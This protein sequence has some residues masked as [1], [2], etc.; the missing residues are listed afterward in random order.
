[1]H[2]VYINHNV[3]DNLFYIIVSILMFF[4]LYDNVSQLKKYK[5]ILLT[6]CMS[7][8]I[9]LCMK[10]PIYI[11]QYC[12]HDLRQ[13]PLFIGTL[14]GGWPTGAALLILLLISR[15]AI[16]GFNL[17]T[18]IVYVVI[19]IATALFSTKFNRLNK[20]KKLF[21]SALITLFLEIITT[22]MAVMISEFFKVTEAYVFYFILVPPL[23]VFFAVYLLELLMDTIHVRSKMVKLEKMEVVSQLAASI[24]HEVRNPLTVVKGFIELLK[25]ANLSQDKKEEYIEHVVRELNNAESII[26][27]YLAFAKPSTEKVEMIIV[28]RE[29]KNIIEILKPWANM[30]S[31]KIKDQLAP[32]SVLGNANYFR[33]CFLN[34][35]KNGVE[36][37]PNGGE[38]EITTFLNKKEL[39]IKVSDT[40]MG[41][42]K[43]QINRFGEPYY[44]SKEKGTGLGSMVAV[45]TI[46]M[47]KGKLEIESVPNEGTTITV[48]FPIY[49]TEKVLAKETPISLKTKVLRS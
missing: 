11:D 10:F 27:D 48:I 39:T 1:M 34:I 40:G 24:S 8:P 4:V 42:T 31:V 22:Y 41:M 6:A 26:S 28:E 16:Y 2:F 3:L 46:H 49:M 18:L 20:K 30:N 25:D 7:L 14:F 38:L 43:E 9:I 29:I 15:F 21:S 44:S 47:M 32:G 19:F 13:I 5:K 12:V 37:M 45:K 17:L 23:V 33:Q 35:M 36:A